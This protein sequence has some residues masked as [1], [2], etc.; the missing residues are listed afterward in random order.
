MLDAA[1]FRCKISL[2]VSV[3]LSVYPFHSLSCS[4]SLHFLFCFIHSILFFIL[5]RAHLLLSLSSPTLSSEL[6]HFLY[7]FNPLPLS[8][9]LSL[10]CEAQQSLCAKCYGSQRQNNNGIFI[11]KVITQSSWHRGYTALGDLLTSLLQ[12]ENTV[13]EVADSGKS[14][15]AGCSDQSCAFK[16]HH[17]SYDCCWKRSRGSVFAELMV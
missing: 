1:G 15:N 8:L 17:H 7:Q 14:V 16:G 6:H 12:P 2:S 3:C 9:S 13:W 10:F 4:L 5:C 11:P